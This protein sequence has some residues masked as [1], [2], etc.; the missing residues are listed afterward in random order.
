MAISEEARH[1]LYQALERTI[2]HDQAATL[3]EHLPPVGW[4][5]VASRRD[6]AL[7][8]QNLQL[9]IDATEARLTALIER[10]IGEA[11]RVHV[12]TS[13]GSVMAAVSLAFAA[14]RL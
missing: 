2:G 13:V 7:T 9:K 10:R 1:E 8:T 14:A 3:M 5:D 12:L 11:V 6:L 4:A